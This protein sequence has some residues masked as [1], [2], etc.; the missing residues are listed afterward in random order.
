MAKD[1]KNVTWFTPQAPLESFSK[2]ELSQLKNWGNDETFSLLGKWF[3]KQLEF[4]LL[5]GL[6]LNKEKNIEMIA[7]ARALQKVMQ[8]VFALPS[9]A[10]K[11]LETFP[12]EETPITT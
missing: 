4:N 3:Y 12:K 10:S 2:A 9:L 7:D 11:K 6:N 8:M 5:A 1:N